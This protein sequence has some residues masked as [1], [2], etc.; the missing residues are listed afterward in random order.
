MCPIKDTCTRND[1]GIGEH[2]EPHTPAD[3]CDHGCDGCPPCVPTDDVCLCAK[4]GKHFWSANAG[5]KECLWCHARRELSA[6]AASEAR[7]GETHGQ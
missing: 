2:C 1:D 5:V 6:N 3:G 7:R 4:T